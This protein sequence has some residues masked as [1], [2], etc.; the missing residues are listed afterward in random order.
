[1]ASKWDIV[2]LPEGL[3]EVTLLELRFTHNYRNFSIFKQLINDGIPLDLILELDEDYL[4]SFSL[5]SG[6]SFLLYL[7][8]K[9]EQFILTYLLTGKNRGIPSYPDNTVPIEYRADADYIYKHVKREIERGNYTYKSEVKDGIEGIGFIATYPYG[10]IDYGFFPFSREELNSQLENVEAFPN[11]TV[12][13]DIPKLDDNVL[14]VEFEYLKKVEDK[15]DSVLA[16]IPTT[17]IIDKTICGCGATYL[18]IVNTKRNSIII[19]PNVPVIIG[20]EHKHKHLIG[21]Y[22][23]DIE[24]KDIIDRIGEQREGVKIMTTPDSYIKVTKALKALNIKY[25]KDWF[26]LFDECEKIVSDIDFRPNIS[27]PIDDFFRFQNKAMVSATPIIVNDPRFAEY[28]FKI[29]KIKPLYDHKK[30]L[31]LKHTNNVS[32]V[33]KRTIKQLEDDS[34]A[35]IFYNSPTGIIELIDLLGIGEQANIYCSTEAKKT[36]KKDGYNVFDT[37]TIEQEKAV[38]NKYNFFTSRFYSAVDIELDYKPTVIMITNAHKAT[39]KIKDKKAR[40][41]SKN[42]DKNTPYTLIDPE[43]EAVQIAGRFRNGIDKLIHIT[44][45]DPKL[46]YHSRAEFEQFLEEQHRGLHKM[47]ELQKSVESYGEQ[48]IIHEA[49]ISTEY[50]REGYVDDYN[51][52]I[53]YFRYNNAYLD[54]RLKMIYR[55]SSTLHKA[56][57]RSEA[58]IVYSNSEY[59]IYTEQ[60]RRILLNKQN[61][62]AL[63]ITLLY[64]VLKRI[65]NFTN[66]YDPELI[67]DL[68]REYAIYIEA[69]PYLKLRKI[70]QLEFIDSKVKT[71]LKNAKRLSQLM[72]KEVTAEVYKVFESNTNYTTEDINN[73]LKPILDKY[74]ISYDLRGTAGDILLYFYGDFKRGTRGVGRWELLGRKY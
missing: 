20:K 58:F 73:G 69:F 2:N 4:P 23:E 22:G 25:L 12:E 21:V 18:E 43:T 41:A 51:G 74:G 16:E 56:Y 33:F 49:I 62:K 15:L 68:K 5:P 40:K 37:I 60:E 26:L 67:A 39:Y 8:P 71:E 35:C 1:M 36:I 66:L 27:L 46:E 42:T 65:E 53:N 61:S 59:A 50:W 14:P 31:E 57:M 55:Y 63:R 17:T 24:V 7:F 19:E 28:G 54:E 38:L 11:P 72:N 3:K 70:K 52:K 47:N 64:D 32:L 48:Y 6:K 45:T 44:D 34:V 30:L 13:Q 10:S 29:L 9:I